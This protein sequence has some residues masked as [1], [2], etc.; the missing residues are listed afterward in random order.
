MNILLFFAFF[1]SGNC[2]IRKENGTVPPQASPK[3]HFFFLSFRFSA[4]PFAGCFF[5]LAKSGELPIRQTPRIKT[6]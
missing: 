5:L 4:P 6:L 1:F 2:R 3:E